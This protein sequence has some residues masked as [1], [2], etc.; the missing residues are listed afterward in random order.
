M[1]RIEQQVK[2]SV[3]DSLLAY[4]GFENIAGRLRRGRSGFGW[5]D[6]WQAG[7][8]RR[9]RLADVVNSPNDVVLDW[10]AAVGDNPTLD[11]RAIHDDELVCVR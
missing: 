5:D 8:Q 6:G 11:R 1:R 7:A 4:D 10:S 9:G 2:E 3:G